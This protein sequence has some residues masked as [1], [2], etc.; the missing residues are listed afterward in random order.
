[1]RYSNK[2]YKNLLF[3]TVIVFL[4]TMVTLAVDQAYTQN[5]N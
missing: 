3:L 5:C 1:M 2:I 4:V